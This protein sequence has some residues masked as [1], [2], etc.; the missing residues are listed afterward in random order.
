MKGFKKL[1][2]WLCVVGAGYFLLSNHIV[3]V[4]SRVKILRKSNLTLD[5]TFFSTQGKATNS[6]LAV[7]EL[8]KAGIGKILVEA[9][10]IS[11]EQLELLVEEM[12]E[13]G[14]E[15]K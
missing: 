8:R 12:A 11:E 4:G 1:L 7:E 14:D 5:Y 15:R 6:I 2:V 9:G 10:K 13:P 3:F